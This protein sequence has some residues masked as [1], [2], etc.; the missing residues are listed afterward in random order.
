[1][2]PHV[3]KP[4]PLLFGVWVGVV[5][6]L[7]TAAIFRTVDANASAA[8]WLAT[9][10][11]AIELVGILLIASPEIRPRVVRTYGD[12]REGARTTARR[13]KTWFDRVF[14]RR[15]VISIGAA[16]GIALA[17]SATAR[18]RRSVPPP[19]K[20]GLAALAD[21]VFEHLGAISGTVDDVRN[22]VS[23]MPA[24][25]QA[26]IAAARNEVTAATAVAI[27]GIA[28]SEVRMRLLGVLYVVAGLGLN[29]AANLISY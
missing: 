7:A 10:G 15:V 4:L 14:R 6:V 1:M 2:D 8:A 22:R 5:A 18:L 29:Y 16:G 13:F 28:E 9:L 27:R 23:A 26:D 11:M 24:E 12:A 21:Y 20:E 3:P 17:G 19:P 25:W